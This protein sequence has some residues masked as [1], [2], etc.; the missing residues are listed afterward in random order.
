MSDKL[1]LETL[2]KKRLTAADWLLRV[3][4]IIVAVV[5]LFWLQLLRQTFP[6]IG[7]FWVSIFAAF[8]IVIFFLFKYTYVE[9][10][11][12]YASGD[13]NIDR[14]TAKNARRR[15]EKVRISDVSL[16]CT[17]D[18]LGGRAQ[19]E[20]ITDASARDKN[21]TAWCMVYSNGKKLAIIQPNEELLQAI[22][23][24]LPRTAVIKKDD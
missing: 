18:K 1:F 19:Y 7:A 16:L 8:V 20:K 13:L 2:V 24:A 22:I 5:V 12:S 17:L 15:L 10:E 14:I 4:S 11:Y 23:N 21:Q 3:G 9:F 6:V